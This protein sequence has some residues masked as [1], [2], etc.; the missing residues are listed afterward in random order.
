[1][2]GTV[3]GFALVLSIPALD[4]ACTTTDCYAAA[5]TTGLWKLANGASVQ[6]A[7]PTLPW[8]DPLGTSNV[9]TSGNNVFALFEHGQA[10]MPTTQLLSLA[11]GGWTPIGAPGLLLTN[12][13]LS[14]DGQTVFAG[15]RSVAGGGFAFV[16]AGGGSSASWTAMPFP[17]ANTDNGG[18]PA[19]DANGTLW[20]IDLRVPRLPVR[21]PLGAAAWSVAG[22][23]W[24]NTLGYGR[25]LRVAYNGDVWVS[26]T[27]FVARLAAGASDWVSIALPPGNGETSG[28]VIDGDNTAYFTFGT[29]Q[30]GKL[31]KVVPN[32]TTAI[33]MGVTVSAT[34]P[35]GPAAID[36][37]GRL[38]FS[39]FKGGTANTP[40]GLYRSTP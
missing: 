2:V 36:G 21:R 10:A 32:G 34:R 14:T 8:A 22:A 19:S 16:A 24:S 18:Y 28:V 25:R 13:S 1:M 31:M 38:L 15:V 30:T 23:G 37:T 3:T 5:E 12:S 27:G 33:D 7:L 20:G 4:L 6:S 39:C 11:S 26:G 29:P 40:G 35:C 9:T 17:F